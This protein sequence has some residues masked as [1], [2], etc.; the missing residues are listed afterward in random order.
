MKTETTGLVRPPL[1]HAQF[2]LVLTAL[3]ECANRR[4]FEAEGCRNIG[5]MP[6]ARELEKVAYE[7]DA[8]AYGLDV[9]ARNMGLKP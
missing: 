9:Y 5:D 8:L 1:T 3:T 2:E 7:F 6:A 4:Q